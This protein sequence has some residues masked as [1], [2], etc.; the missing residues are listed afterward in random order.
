MLSKEALELEG[1]DVAANENDNGGPSTQNVDQHVR[2]P[3]TLRVRSSND[4]S[5]PGGKRK[6][7]ISCGICRVEGHTRKSCPL[8]GEVEKLKKGISGSDVNLDDD[9]HVCAMM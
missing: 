2:E 5:P 6:R 9:E 1:K 8:A 4:L 3:K 7:I